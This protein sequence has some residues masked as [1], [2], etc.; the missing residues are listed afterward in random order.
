MMMVMWMMT[1]MIM[2]IPIERTRRPTSPFQ[3]KIQDQKRQANCKQI[4][5]FLHRKFVFAFNAN[6]RHF[7][8]NH[9]WIANS[10][11]SLLEL[12]KNMKLHYV[13]QQCAGSLASEDGSQLTRHS[14]SKCQLPSLRQ[15]QPYRRIIFTGTRTKRNAMNSIAMLT[16][17]LPQRKLSWKVNT[18]GKKFL[19]VK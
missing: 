1:A 2:T 19:I 14:N 9:D 16:F 10:T 3:K 8:W 7:K 4:S 12:W 17:F 11:P 13:I 5:F 15:L 6:S 18:L